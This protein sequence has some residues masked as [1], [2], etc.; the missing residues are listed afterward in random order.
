MES[1]SSDIKQIAKHRRVIEWI[2]IIAGGFS[3]ITGAYWFYRTNIWIPRITIKNVDYK[4]GTANITIEGID[5]YLLNN[6][7]LTAGGNWGIRFNGQTAGKPDRIELVKN[8][9]TYRLLDVDKTVWG[10][11]I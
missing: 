6:Y 3:V 10:N 4:N 8:G 7:S 2:V 1:V 9:I 5:K 11:Q